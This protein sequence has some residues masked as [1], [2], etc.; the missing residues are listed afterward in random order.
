MRPHWEES[1]FVFCD[2]QAATR[3]MHRN[4]PR[5]A[6]AFL[7]AAYDTF[8]FLAANPAVGRLPSDLGFPDVR[9]WGVAGFRNYL[10]SYRQIPE[11]VQ[12][13]RVLHGAW[14]LGSTLSS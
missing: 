9:S 11:G 5:L 7:E 12:V 14:D 13:W 1:E 8:Q 3:L 6:R 10:I 4:N 2:L